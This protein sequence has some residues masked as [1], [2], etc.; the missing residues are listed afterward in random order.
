L[1]D[2]ADHEPDERSCPL[3]QRSRRLL[4][5]QSRSSSHPAKESFS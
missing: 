2:S 1:V 4:A 5:V 3:H